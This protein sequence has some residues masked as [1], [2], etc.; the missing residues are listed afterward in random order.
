M[1]T[2]LILGVSASLY[3]RYDNKLQSVGI[4]GKE[5]YSD[6]DGTRI[7]EEISK[8]ILFSENLNLAGKPDRVERTKNDHIRIIEFK[9]GEKPKEPHENHLLQLG[10]YALLIE[11]DM[12]VEVNRALIKYK[13]GDFKIKITSKM[14]KKVKKKIRQLYKIKNNGKVPQRNHDNLGKCYQCDYRRRCPDPVILDE[15]KENM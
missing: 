1:T 2:L 10:C 6:L 11:D 14:K 9:S 5:L 7:S 8:P 15:L 12:G 3:K 4:K 13:D